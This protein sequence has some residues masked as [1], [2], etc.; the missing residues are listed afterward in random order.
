MEDK[1]RI[2]CS[3]FHINDLKVGPLCRKR[4]LRPHIVQILY[5]NMIGFL[6]S[7]LLTDTNV[8][9]VISLRLVGLRILGS[10]CKYVNTTGHIPLNL[11]FLFFFKEDMGLCCY[12]Y[13]DIFLSFF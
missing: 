6:Y 5:V 11:Q 9:K 10:N 12:S 1:K 7:I 4:R 2:I 13:R 8:Q 3:S